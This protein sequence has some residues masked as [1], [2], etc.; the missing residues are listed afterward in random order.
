MKRF[1]ILLCSALFLTIAINAQERMQIAKGLYIVRYGNVTVIE[2]DIN[3][4]TI[5][6]KVEKEKKTTGQFV[7]KVMCGNKYTKTVAK[8]AL[9]MTIK[10]AVS[11]TGIGAFGANAVASIASTVYDDV[12]NYYAKE[13]EK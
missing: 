2:D 4:R 3:Q 8:T 10:A 6:L 9:S 12:C 7:Y 11:S 5:Q 1:F 13:Y